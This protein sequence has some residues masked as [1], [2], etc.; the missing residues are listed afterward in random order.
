MNRWTSL[1]TRWP[2]ALRLE[3]AGALLVALALVLAPGWPRWLGATGVL[4][5]IAGRRLARQAA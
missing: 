5:V 3:L 2:L 1:W 4:L